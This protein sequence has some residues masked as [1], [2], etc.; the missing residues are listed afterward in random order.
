ML[1]S[2]SM[3]LQVN[4]SLQAARDG[5]F[6][7]AS[8]FTLAGPAGLMRALSVSIAVLA[9]VIVAFFGCWFLAAGCSRAHIFVR[10]ESG[11]AISNLV[12][13]GTCKERRM[14]VVAPLSAWK[15]VSPYRS[16]GQFQFSFMWDGRSYSNRPDTGA[17]LSGFCGISLIVGS[18]MVVRSE[19]RK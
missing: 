16:P 1:E 7:S 12:I 8:R 5:G 9:S 17:D 14:D 11:G 3:K 4:E 2:L 10:N 6:S 15:T 13:S 18:N 19:V